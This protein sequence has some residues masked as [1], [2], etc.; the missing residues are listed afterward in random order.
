MS[1]QT[2]YILITTI[3]NWFWFVTWTKKDWLNVI[4]KIVFLI[5]AVLGTIVFLDAIG[6]I[7]QI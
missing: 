1:I 2:I 5:L 3:A 6:L 4:F 7:V